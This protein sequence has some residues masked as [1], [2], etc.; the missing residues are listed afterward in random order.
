MVDAFY[1]GMKHRP[2]STFGTFN[3]DF[4]AYKDPGFQRENVCSMILDCS[5][6]EREPVWRKAVYGCLA[7]AAH[8]LR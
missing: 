3:D 7:V 1:E 5:I 8:C 4:L 6:D 2:Q